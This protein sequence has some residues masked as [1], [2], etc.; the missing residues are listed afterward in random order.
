MGTTDPLAAVHQYISDF[1]KGDGEAMAESFAVPGSILD[2]MAPH[3]WRGPTAAVPSRRWLELGWRS[4]R[5]AQP[6]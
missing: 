6:Q 2:G 5:V 3:V 1:N 4:L